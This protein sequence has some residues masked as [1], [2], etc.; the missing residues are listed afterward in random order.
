[1]AKQESQGVTMTHLLLAGAALAGAFAL[2]ACGGQSKMAKQL[3]GICQQPNAA[4]LPRGDLPGYIGLDCSCVIAHLDKGV[5]ERLKPAFVAL[6]WPLA[7]D[8]RDREAVNG[9][10]LRDAGIDPT[11][12]AAV[13]SANAE[14]RDT[15]HLLDP[16]IRAECKV[17]G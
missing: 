2:S 9:Q 10:M 15:L 16:Q 12:Y 6:R 5:P 7:P 11:D 17:A 1:M 13:S 8:P 14:L 3:N 4:G